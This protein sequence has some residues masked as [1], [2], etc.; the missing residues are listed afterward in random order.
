MTSSNA[1]NGG[2]T[3]GCYIET[4]AVASLHGDGVSQKLFNNIKVQNS[5]LSLTM[6]N[7][8]KISINNVC[9]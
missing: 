9:R 6:N 7:N 8:D 1:E 4:I 5:P 2:T 3:V